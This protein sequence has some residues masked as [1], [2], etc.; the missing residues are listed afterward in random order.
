MFY[1]ALSFPSL[2]FSPDFILTDKYWWYWKSIMYLTGSFKVRLKMSN[3]FIAKKKEWFYLNKKLSWQFKRRIYNRIFFIY[4]ITYRGIKSILCELKYKFFH[5][6]CLGFSIKIV[7]FLTQWK[8]YDLIHVHV[9]IYGSEYQIIPRI[10][11]CTL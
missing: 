3:I 11:L 1:F 2:W 5:C 6:F 8:F 7:Q 10:S 4:S 9:H